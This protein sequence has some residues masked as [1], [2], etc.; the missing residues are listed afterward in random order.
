MVHPGQTRN[1][2]TTLD[3]V[4]YRPG[5]NP[6]SLR[7]EKPSGCSCFTYR[8]G[9]IQKSP[10]SGSGARY[11]SMGSKAS[12]TSCRLGRRRRLGRCGFGSAF[13]AKGLAEG[14]LPREE[15]SVGW[16]AGRVGKFIMDERSF[17]VGWLGSEGFGL[18]LRLGWAARG[19]LSGA[20]RGCRWTFG[21]PESDGPM[22]LFLLDGCGRPWTMAKTPFGKVV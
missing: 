11:S 4:V 3:S 1:F 10:G 21:K 14:L 17:S 8:S 18:G 12:R 13:S 6:H 19:A 20:D 9:S 7:G 2:G 16:A 15:N 5:A 22:A